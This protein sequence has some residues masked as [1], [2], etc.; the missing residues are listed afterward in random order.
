VPLVLIILII[1]FVIKPVIE[2]L[3]A[4]P[5]TRGG[6]VPSE[7]T[8]A[9]T[10]AAAAAEGEADTEEAMKEKLVDVVKKDP[11]RAAT[12]LKEWMAE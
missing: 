2:T 7:L 1:F 3:K 4:M 10:A 9:G 5:V 6:G 12:I 8:L 11:R